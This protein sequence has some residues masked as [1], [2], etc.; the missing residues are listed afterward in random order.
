[1]AKLVGMGA[2][3]PAR[4]HIEDP[5]K[6]RHLE[7]DCLRQFDR[8]QRASRIAEHAKRD[9]PEIADGGKHAQGF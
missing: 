5:E 7:R 6:A 8:H 2:P 4:G 3:N 9:R 1:M